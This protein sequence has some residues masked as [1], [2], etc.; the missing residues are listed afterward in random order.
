MN[1]DGIYVPWESR[2]CRHLAEAVEKVAIMADFDV[3]F[4]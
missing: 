3:R 2:E 1:D 4:W